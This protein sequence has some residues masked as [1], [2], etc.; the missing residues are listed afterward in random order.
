MKNM[1]GAPI[2]K[3][4]GEEMSPRMRKRVDQARRMSAVAKLLSR[5]VLKGAISA[6]G[7]VANFLGTAISGAPPVR[8]FMSSDARRDVVVASVDAFAQVVEAV[9]TAGKSLAMVTSS[10]GTEIVQQKFGE[11]VGLVAQDGMG[12]MGNMI[13]SMW[14]LNKLGLYMLWRAT[15]ASTVLNYGFRSAGSSRSGSGTSSDQTMKSSSPGLSINSGNR[16]SLAIGRSIS[17]STPMSLDDVP[18]TAQLFPNAP[19][20]NPPQYFAMAPSTAYAA[21]TQ[22]MQLPPTGYATFYQ[23]QNPNSS[24]QHYTRPGVRPTV[25]T[26]FPNAT[27]ASK[28]Q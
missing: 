4:D 7:H 5:T 25:Q 20:H 22:S 18:Q 16:Q 9:E 23:P 28:P 3:G 13:D 27:E 24:F 2:V 17:P 12:A 19:D 11:Q 26:F 21:H 10:V 8:A 14:T 1:A 6:T 15:T